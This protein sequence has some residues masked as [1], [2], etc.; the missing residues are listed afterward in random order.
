MMRA[1]L[2]SAT[3]FREV[4]NWR[5]IIKVLRGRTEVSKEEQSHKQSVKS[6]EA[7]HDFSPIFK[8]S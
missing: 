5:L 8:E 6:N 3:C 2:M 7:V 1:S 4:T